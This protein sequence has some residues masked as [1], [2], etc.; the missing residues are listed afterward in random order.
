MTKITSVITA[1]LVAVAIFIFVFER[2]LLS[3]G[4]DEVLANET[5]TKD[6]P[7]GLGDKANEESKQTAAISVVVLSSES[8]I[9]DNLVTLNGRTEA[10]R[11]VDLFAETA[12][13]VISEPLRKGTFVQSGQPMCALDPGTREVNLLEA[14]ARLAEARARAPEA[15]ARLAEAEARLS[16]AVINE[17]AAV[18]LQADGFA[19]ETRVAATKAT[20]QAAQAGVAGAKS[21][22]ETTLAG[23]QSAE[24]GVATAEKEI[25]RLTI[26]AS[27]D[28]VLESD[29]AELGSLLQPGGLCATVIQLDPIKF[30][31]FVPETDVAQV[32]AGA[33]A[34][35]QLITGETAVGSVTFL[36]RSADTNTRTFRVEIQI[37]NP[38]LKIRDG[39]TAGITIQA[40]G[41]KAHFLPGSALTLDGD[42]TLGVRT[43]QADNAVKFIPVS[44]LRDT[45]EGVWVDGLPQLS[46]VIVL[47]QEYVTDGIIVNPVYKD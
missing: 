38:D 22:L 35:V 37:P 10:V 3:P 5:D 30:V 43:V 32:N 1:V 47:G 17:N 31:G 15:Q 11:K 23:I 24:A 18:K 4:R 9:I 16:E 27:F 44:V 46:D 2:D 40:E 20:L 39:Q 25:S 21:G 41:R 7:V 33:N 36:S 42:G 19:S 45:T 12:G 13:R 26:S 29:T 28:G 34:Q 14:R 8:Q 6:Q